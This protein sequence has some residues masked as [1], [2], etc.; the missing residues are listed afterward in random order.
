MFYKIILIIIK[1]SL[2]P[3]FRI[4]ISGLENLENNKKIIICANHKSLLDPIFLAISLPMKIN[5]MAKKELFENPVFAFILKSLYAFPVDRNGLDLK[6][7]RYAVS[8]VDD[9]KVLGIFPEGTRVKE[10]KRENVKDGVAFVAL[11]AKADILPIEIISSYKLF[12]RTEI[13]IKKAVSV[14]KFLSL[15]NKEAMKK[16][17]DEVFDNIY[18]NHTIIESESKWK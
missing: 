4:K 10:V 6:A 2:M 17:T 3:L 12:R 9:G 11:K 13:I 1:I 16:M 18:E 15:K 7:L 5:F 14:D 8:L